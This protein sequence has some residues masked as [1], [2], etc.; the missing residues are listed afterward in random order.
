MKSFDEFVSEHH[1]TKTER[2]A[3]VWHLAA[4]RAR[5][6]VEMLLPELYGTIDPRVCAPPGVSGDERAV[7]LH[8]LRDVPRVR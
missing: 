3:L 5:R 7:Y 2:T 1:L 6:T 8:H 4:F